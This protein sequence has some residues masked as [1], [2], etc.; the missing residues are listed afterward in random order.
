MLRAIIFDFNGVIL[1]D[2]TWH[3]E[4]LAAVLAEEGVDLPLAKLEIDVVVG[5][6]PVE[7]LVDPTEFDGQGFR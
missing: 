2:E 5:L 1:D 4:A 3:Y 7:G 6:H